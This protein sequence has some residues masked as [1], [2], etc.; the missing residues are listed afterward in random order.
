MSP[1]FT[2]RGDDVIHPTCLCTI[3]WEQ[4]QPPLR[5]VWC[6]FN[7]NMV[8]YV[9]F[10]YIYLHKVQT[11]NLIVFCLIYM[12][13]VALYCIHC[14]QLLIKFSIRFLGVLHFTVWN[15]RIILQSESVSGLTIL[16]VVYWLWS[17]NDEVY[18][19]V[20]AISLAI[21]I[22]LMEWIWVIIMSMYN[23]DNSEEW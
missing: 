10:M 14:M 1:S 8:N 15:S 13:T 23:H 12:Y 6:S 2:C 19:F 21:E 5:L 17:P 16:P 11:E 9:I 18:C 22:K 20:S 3:L 7:Y 4:R